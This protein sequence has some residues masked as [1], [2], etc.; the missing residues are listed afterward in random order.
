MLS[1]PLLHCLHQ[2]GNKENEIK[3]HYSQNYTCLAMI[4]NDDGSTSYM[5]NSRI[6]LCNGDMIHVSVATVYSSASK[7]LHNDLAKKKLGKA[8]VVPV[9][10]HTG[11]YPLA[12]NTFVVWRSFQLSSWFRSLVPPQQ[13]I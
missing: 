13:P 9:T 6:V 3:F 11:C 2:M 10:V 4:V 5:Y 8:H 1:N 7:H 12:F